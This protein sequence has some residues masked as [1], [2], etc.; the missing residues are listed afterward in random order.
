MKK[1]GWLFFTTRKRL[2]RLEAEV[3]RLG[4]MLEGRQGGLSVLLTPQ[5]GVPLAQVISE[6]LYGEEENANG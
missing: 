3:E 5:E 1:Q 2:A 4:G 6:Y